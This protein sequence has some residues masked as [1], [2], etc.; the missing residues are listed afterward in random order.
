[1]SFFERSALDLA[2]LV[3]NREVGPV[4]LLES[5]ID[6][7]ERVNPALNAVVEKRYDQAREEARAAEEAVAK[8]RKLGP[9]HGVPCTVKEFLAVEGLRQTGGLVIRRDFV[10]Q[11]DSTVVDR[12]KAAGAIVMGT[13]NAPEGGLWHETH[14]RVYGRT[15]NPHDL[16]RTSGGSS[17][18]EG[19]IVA[20]GAS[21]FGIGSDVGG[22]IRI[23]SAF[24]GI[25]GHKPTHGIVPNTG[26][27]PSAPP[28]PYMA[29]GPMARSAHDLMPL[30]RVLS[31]PDGHDPHARPWKL[32]DPETVDLSGLTVYPMPTNG[33]ASVSPAVQAAVMDAAT[34]LQ[35]RGASIRELDVPKLRHAFKIW[36]TLM[37]SLGIEYDELVTDGGIVPLRTEFRRWA[38]G[39]SRH[40]GAVLAMIALERAMHRLPDQTERMRRLAAELQSE[41]EVALGDNGVMLHPPFS[42]V[43]PHHRTIGIGNPTDAGVTAVFNILQFPVTVAPVG[44]SDGVPTAVQIIGRRGNDHLTIAAGMALEDAL[45]GWVPVEPR[46]GPRPRLRLA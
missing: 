21:P 45:G 31:G 37:S 11:R 32:G 22:S 19:A 29:V 30:L 27:F 34:A 44:V 3:R 12:L 1:M 23:P 33:E 10:S 15:A 8:K 24:C 2:A 17:G 39:R 46:R 18:G 7:I 43:A 41:L 42:R 35:N 25:Y 9:L 6:R 28:E 20:S 38:Q 36:A 13:T 26:H 16:Y 5:H 4:E 14:N 40:T